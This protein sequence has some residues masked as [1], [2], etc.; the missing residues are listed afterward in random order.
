MYNSNIGMDM[1]KINR[2]RIFRLI[3]K[4][5]Q[6]SKQDIV[7]ALNI[8]LPT[9]I[10]NLKALKEAGLIREEGCFAS[11]GGRK[12]RAIS[13]NPTARFSI[14]VDITKNL[15]AIAA[16][17]LCA[18]I[19]K[20]THIRIPFENSRE[21]FRMVGKYIEQFTEDPLIDRSKILGVGIS[22]PGLLSEDHQNIT[23]ASVL[24]FTGGSL[25]SFAEFIPYPC[26]L[27]N[28]ASAAALAELWNC[29]NSENVVYL[30]LSNS[31]GGAIL[32]GKKFY[33]GENQ[34][35]AEF[36][37]MT[38]VPRG[39]RCYCGQHG[40]AD[41]YCNASI[42]SDAANGSLDDFFRQLDAGSIQHQ[43]IW[44]KYVH[45]LTIMINNLR[46]MFDCRVILGGYVGSYME[47]HIEALVKKTALR[48]S[49]EK[50]GSYLE[51]CRY[52]KDSSAVGAALLHIEAFINSI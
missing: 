33:P 6:L 15:I 28:D 27:S 37:H 39:R 43:N 8:S 1:K 20:S 40:C 14:G 24:G 4:K 52:R 50:D 22:V 9:V 31:V 17:D 11:T 25:D 41:A 12:A 48:N 38:I 19:V 3:Y 30:S 7:H 45:H 13:C 49:F 47:R 51:T 32:L 23:Y 21:Y 36:G 42:L 34:R 44:K 18:A 5:G 16:I 26:F 29:D 35:S 10:Q 2:N 46:M